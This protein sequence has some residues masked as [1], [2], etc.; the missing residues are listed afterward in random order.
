MGTTKTGIS[1]C[2]GKI[3]WKR[4]FPM[5]FVSLFL[6]LALAVSI[7]DSAGAAS[8]TGSSTIGHSIAGSKSL[9]L[10]RPA[11]TAPGDFLLACIAAQTGTTPVTLSAPG[12]SLIRHTQV[13]QSPNSLPAN[14]DM[15]MY[16]K[17]SGPSEPDSYTFSYTSTETPFGMNGGI[18]RYSGIWISNPIEEGS[19]IENQGT[20]TT[21]SGSAVDVYQSYE[22][23]IT[24]F[25]A[26]EGV[27]DFSVPAGTS[28]VYESEP[29]ASSGYTW[30]KIAMDD[31]LTP[32]ILS[33][34][35]HMPA[36]T[37][38]LTLA[39]GLSE[40]AWGSQTIAVKGCPTMTI[41]E[42]SSIAEEWSEYII[43]LNLD[44][45]HGT[46]GASVNYAVTGG[47]ALYGVDY[48]LQAGK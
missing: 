35:N 26:S 8:T 13:R 45:Y 5:A 34:H 24:F 30:P 22:K 9:T 41:G 42:S 37:S 21:A 11:D 14:F 1:R 29:A 7:P 27:I 12:W 20:G 28:Q 15:F 39:D 32:L 44:F 25:A 6:V 38:N 3:L 47:T 46:Y 16:Y 10:D 40:V 36:M 23:L 48:T 4:V 18:T 19:S 17:L 43:P 2:K 31:R 33:S